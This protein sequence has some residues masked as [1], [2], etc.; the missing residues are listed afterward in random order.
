MRGEEFLTKH[1]G[2]E[3]RS[4]LSADHAVWLGWSFG[5]VSDSFRMDC[6]W[7]ADWGI[8]A[9]E[10]YK[11]FFDKWL[12]QMGP[13]ELHYSAQRRGAAKVGLSVGWRASGC[14][15]HHGTPE[16]VLG[17]AALGRELNVCTALKRKR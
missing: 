15:R 3:T 13:I 14:R 17:A 5:F 7:A 6:G 9:G 2:T 1:G 10:G 16:A 11:S 8:S 12:L 4:G